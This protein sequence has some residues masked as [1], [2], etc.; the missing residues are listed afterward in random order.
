VDISAQI[1]NTVSALVQARFLCHWGPQCSF[2]S[3]LSAA[4]VLPSGEYC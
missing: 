3:D 2:G 1:S 4:L